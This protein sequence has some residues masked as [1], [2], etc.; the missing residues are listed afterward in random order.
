M[1][2]KS[3][4]ARAIGTAVAAAVPIAKDLWD[5]VNKDDRAADALR[6]GYSSARTSAA[7]RTPLGKVEATVASVRAYARTTSDPRAGAWMQRADEISRLIPLARLQR[8]RERKASTKHL[9]TMASELLREVIN[10]GS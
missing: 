7:A 6:K 2:S 1:P 5:V 4:R 10:L 3:I 8:G 9:Q